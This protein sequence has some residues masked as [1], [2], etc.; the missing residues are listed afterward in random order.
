MPMADTPIDGLDQVAGLRR[1][2]GRRELYQSLLRKFADG[3]KDAV[4]RMRQ[5]LAADDWSGAE[6]LAH[7]LKGVA[8]NIGAVHVQEH[9]GVLEK[10]LRDRCALHETEPLLAALEARLGALCRALG[11]V[12]P[13]RREAAPD[14]VAAADP[15]KVREACEHMRYLL[16]SDSSEALDLLRKHE[17]LL[18]NAFPTRID[19]LSAA[20]NDYD[21]GQALTL[22][23]EAMR[24]DEPA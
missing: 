6:R 15:A 4:V 13:E 17:A 1:V 19:A 18:R 8:G 24:A 14:P 9:A 2:L 7:T 21:F 12:Q 22:L 11:S 20:V 3:Q 5:A 23:D 10:A 16:V